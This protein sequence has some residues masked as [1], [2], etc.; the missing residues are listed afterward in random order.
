MKNIPSLLALALALA[1]A[2]VFAEKADRD[3]PMNVEADSLRY[4]D[5]QQTSVF[6]GKVVV[7]K[8]TIV[9]RGGKMTVHQDPEGYQYGV[10]TAEPGKRAF[11]RQKREGVDEFIEGEGDSID[12]DGKA[13]RVKFIG[14]AEMRRLRG[15]TVNDE[16]SGSVIT[17]DNS[18]DQFTVDGGVAAATP[19]NPGGRVKATLAPRQAASGAAA[20]S[21]TAASGAAAA[22]SAPRPAA[23]ATPPARLR[24]STTL[25]QQEVR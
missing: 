1:A 12:Y 2:P 10:V 20:A 4:D 15:A 16:T 7:T 5:L 22:A 25:G 17:Y 3:K 21:G 6:T 14:R 19:S 9:I 11:F 23:S 8:G 13:D 24:P 18:N